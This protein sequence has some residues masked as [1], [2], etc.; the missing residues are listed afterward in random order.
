MALFGPN[1]K[2][3]STLGSYCMPLKELYP[4]KSPA[5]ALSLLGAGVRELFLN[6]LPFCYILTQQLKNCRNS[7]KNFILIRHFFI[8]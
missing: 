8:C 4:K 6:L 3:A 7:F 1:L 5:Q 2:P